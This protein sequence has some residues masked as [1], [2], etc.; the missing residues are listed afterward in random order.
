MSD[1]E[2]F[3]SF[4]RKMGVPFAF[5]AGAPQFLSIGETLFHFDDSGA[6]T[7]VRDDYGRH[8]PRCVHAELP[9]EAK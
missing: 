7:D 3:I 2:R 1:R 9:P 4:F 5:E 6:F 8:S